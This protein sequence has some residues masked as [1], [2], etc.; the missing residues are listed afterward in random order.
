MYVCMY[1]MY[2]F[3]LFR[4][5]LFCF[6]II[7]KTIS[8]I[9]TQEAILPLQTSPWVAVLVWQNALNI[10]IGNITVSRLKISEAWPGLYTIIWRRSPMVNV[11]NYCQN[12]RWLL[13]SGILV[14][15]RVG[16]LPCL[17]NYL[18]LSIILPYSKLVW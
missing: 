7:R 18:Y 17:V 2:W 1:V 14:L 5:G 11:Y 16:S 12:L 15:L 4:H 8:L 10:V 3:N 9:S 6:K 13:Y